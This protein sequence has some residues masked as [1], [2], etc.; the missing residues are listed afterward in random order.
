MTAHAEEKEGILKCLEGS[1]M[2]KSGGAVIPMDNK[3]IVYLFGA[4][5]VQPAPRE[6]LTKKYVIF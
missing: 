4:R 5:Q 3:D 6:I 1:K 2:Q